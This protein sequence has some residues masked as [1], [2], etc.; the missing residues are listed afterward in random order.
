MH[1]SVH[2]RPQYMPA[3]TRFRQH[4]SELFP[5]YARGGTAGLPQRMDEKAAEAGIAAWNNTAKV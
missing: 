5:T 2:A 4:P 3:I 1:K